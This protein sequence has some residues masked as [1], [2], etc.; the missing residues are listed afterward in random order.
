MRQVACDANPCACV[1]SVGVTVALYALFLR[2]SGVQLPLN[3]E[4]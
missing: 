3:D 2:A 4:S 1:H